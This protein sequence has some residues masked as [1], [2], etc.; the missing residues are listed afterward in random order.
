MCAS[1]HHYA[2]ADKIQTNIHDTYVPNKTDRTADYFGPNAENDYYR[3]W[4]LQQRSHGGTMLTTPGECMEHSHGPPQTY[5]A[6]STDSSFSAQNSR[7]SEHLYESPKFDHQ[8]MQMQDV[9]GGHVKY[10][11]LDPETEAHLGK[12]GLSRDSNA[13]GHVH[14]KTDSSSVKIV[15]HCWEHYAYGQF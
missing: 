11:E 5:R 12:H 1:R 9:D 10:F 14:K 8:E 4:Q 15:W 13:V 6:L 2:T 3:T 7:Y